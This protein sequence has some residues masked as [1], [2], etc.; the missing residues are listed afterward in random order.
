MKKLLN[1]FRRKSLESGLQRELDYH[2]E[3]RISDFERSGL[4]P[5]EARRQARLELG[6]TAQ[7]AE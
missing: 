3:R 1:W 7:I 6:G 2:L 5:Q 4:S